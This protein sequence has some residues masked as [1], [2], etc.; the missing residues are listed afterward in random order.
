[1]CTA[2]LGVYNIVYD[3]LD[4][5]VRFAYAVQYLTNILTKSYLKANTLSHVSS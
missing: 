2:V 5:C 1:V 3:S 4:L